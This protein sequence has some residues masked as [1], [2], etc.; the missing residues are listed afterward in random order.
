MNK[1]SIKNLIINACHGVHDYE[2]KKKQRFVFSVDMYTDFYFAFKTDELSETVNYSAACN[3][4]NEVA[5]K[6]SFNLIE[7]LAY[8]VCNALFESQKAIK[9]IVLT[10]EKPDAPVKMEFESVS[11]TV[12][13]TR[14]TAYLSLGSSMGD[15]QKTL[16]DAISTLKKVKGV[17]V[18]KISSYI[19]T[20]PYGGV[21]QN[22]F[23]NCAVEIETFL[24]P[25]QLL[26][27]LNRIE[28]K[29]MRMRDKRW[30]DRTLDMDIIFYGKEVIVED[31]LI[32]PHADY[33][34]RDFVLTPLKEIAPEFIVPVKNM[35]IKNL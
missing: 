24:S 25:R 7:K 30:D 6:N 12:D 9:R 20:K 16:T 27:E 11:A 15:K 18:N 32:I 1:V 14:Q 26:R 10:V 31:D 17:T 5:T 2:K 28:A 34:N 23:Y 35:K 19:K 8:E 21:A 33:L 22:D 3:V 13:L 4:I 29:F